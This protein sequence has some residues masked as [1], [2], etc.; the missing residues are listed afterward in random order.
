MFT[1]TEL[2]GCRIIAMH[3]SFLLSWAHLLQQSTF[4][5]CLFLHTDFPPGFWLP[6]LHLVLGQLQLVW[7][8]GSE[9]KGAFLSQTCLSPCD[10]LGIMSSEKGKGRDGSWDRSKE[11]TSTCGP[12]WVIENSLSLLTYANGTQTTGWNLCSGNKAMQ[13][14]PRLMRDAQG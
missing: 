11:Q 5:R 8:P 9:L 10:F 2:E 12:P 13:M 7:G 3:T 4:C 1:E 6:R 14:G